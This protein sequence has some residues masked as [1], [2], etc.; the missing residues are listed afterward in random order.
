MSLPHQELEFI[1]KYDDFRSVC[2]ALERCGYSKL[3]SQYKEA[4]E[5][6]NRFGVALFH[7][8]L[9]RDEDEPDNDGFESL[10]ESNSVFCQAREEKEKLWQQIALLQKQVIEQSCQQAQ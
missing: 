9:R 7:M 10:M 5:T 8:Q 2:E 6:L 4:C 1:K 3:A